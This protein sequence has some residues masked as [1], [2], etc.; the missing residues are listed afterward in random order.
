[1]LLEWIL[2]WVFKMG[3]I[4]AQGDDIYHID[5]K[6]ILKTDAIHKSLQIPHFIRNCTVYNKKK[7]HTDFI[8]FIYA[9]YLHFYFTPVLVT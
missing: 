3:Y 2:K 5:G 1:M 9:L 8:T 7:K 4:K 6:L